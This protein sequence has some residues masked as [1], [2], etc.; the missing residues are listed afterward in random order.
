MSRKRAFKNVKLSPLSGG[1]SK[2]EYYK[3]NRK[4]VISNHNCYAYALNIINHDFKDMP[5]PGY[6]GGYEYIEVNDI[7][8]D[9]IF[10]RIVADNPSI[11]KT[12]FNQKCKKGYCKAYFA[13]D[14]DKPDYHFYRLNT[15]Q[16]WT[17]KVGNL[18]VSKYDFSY[19]K[20]TNPETSNRKSDFFNY[21]I[22]GG[23]FCYDPMNVNISA[24]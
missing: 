2:P 15:N 21:R 18:K 6:N 12:T 16:Y 19:K 17:H 23:F 9:S 10:K 5:Q 3:W 7:N 20:I 1:E 4:N 22:S 8:I 13:I 24:L 11:K 14:P